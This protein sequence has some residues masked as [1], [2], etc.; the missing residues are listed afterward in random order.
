MMSPADVQQFFEARGFRPYQTSFAVHFVSNDPQWVML[1]SP[2]GSGRSRMAIGIAAAVAQSDPRA[3]ILIVA[4]ARALVEQYRQQLT[5]FAPGRRVVV[6]DRKLW[7]TLQ[8][9]KLGL[10]EP[11]IFVSTRRTL[12]D[13]EIKNAV[14]SVE[15]DL[16]VV[17]EIHAAPQASIVGLVDSL[18][19]GGRV[20]R[21]LALSS[22]DDTPKVLR[23]AERVTWKSS[24][25]AADFPPGFTAALTPEVTTYARS[26]EESRFWDLLDDIESGAPGARFALLSLR[27][28]AHS[29]LYAA[30]LTLRHATARSQMVEFE[31]GE[32]ASRLELMTDLDSKSRYQSLSSSDARRLLERL[33]LIAVD[34]KLDRLRALLVAAPTTTV[35][36]TRFADTARYVAAAISDNRDDVALVTGSTSLDE[37]EHAW[38]A[39]IVVV[40]D[41]TLLQM[42][43]VSEA[44]LIHYDLPDTAPQFIERVMRVAGRLQHG[45][46][47]LAICHR[48]ELARLEMLVRDASGDA[49]K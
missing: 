30:E 6:L 44:W 43:F 34:S 13:P 17:D 15:W 37:R 36:C 10:R 47:A 11:I 16:L 31:P 18:K 25:F 23:D 24:Q 7:R 46:R 21:L 19:R 45:I 42:R 14:I 2:V 3:R 12:S 8:S 39:A 26:A 28:R 48:E 33:E 32:D 40:T 29:S 1:S 4:P 41:A 35:I 20:K 9:A 49:P 5:E 38:H 27:K 22:K